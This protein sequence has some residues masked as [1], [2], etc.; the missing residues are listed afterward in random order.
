MTSTAAMIP[1]VTFSPEAYPIL[2]SFD[3]PAIGDCQ[4]RTHGGKR[5][6][7]SRSNVIGVTYT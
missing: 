2:G 4:L 3:L 7:A 6:S 5:R 1:V